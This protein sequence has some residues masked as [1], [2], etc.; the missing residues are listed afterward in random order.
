MAS[1]LML[2][3]VEFTPLRI[4]FPWLVDMLPALETFNVELAWA[5]HVPPVSVLPENCVTGPATVIV[6]SWASTV[7]KL[8]KAAL[9]CP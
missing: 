5:I 9:I 3:K 8:F 7:P 1:E 4:T 6:P 2:A